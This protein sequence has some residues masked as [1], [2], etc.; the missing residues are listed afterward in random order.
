MAEGREGRGVSVNPDQ[1]NAQITANSS[2]VKQHIA[3][4]DPKVPCEGVQV[5]LL[6]K[7]KTGW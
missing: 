3:T 2:V 1:I 4:S 6:R 7:W 5:P